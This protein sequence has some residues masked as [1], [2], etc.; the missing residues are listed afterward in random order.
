MSDLLKNLNDKQREAVTAPLGP[1][2][3]LAGAGSGKTRAL[4][5]RIAYIIKEKLF[6][7]EEILALTFTNKAA[8]EMKERINKL[9]QATSYKLQIPITMGTFH[10]VC[11]RI[12]RAD[13][14]KLGL[15]YDRNFTIYDSDDSQR[16]VKQIVLELGLSES[17]RPQVFSYYISAAKNKLLSPGQ[18][19]LEN[20]YLQES[21][22]KV[23]GRYK[24]A[25]RENNAVDFDDLLGLAF[26]LFS[27]PEI[28]K[29]YQ[30]RFHYVLVDEYQ[31]TNH[32]QYMLLR[33]L[34]APSASLRAGK[35]NL[36]VV[37]DDAQS[38][39]GFRGANMQNILDFKKDYSKARVIMLEQNYRS[40]KPILDVAN[41]V[42]RLNPFQY[43]KKLWTSNVAGNKVNLYEA[44]D[45]LEEARFILKRILNIESGI[46]NEITYKSEETPIL[47]RFARRDFRFRHIPYSNFQIPEDLNESVI[48]YR[49]H[50]QSRP[51]EEVLVSSGVPYQ[52][53]GGIRFYERREIKDVLA[54][55]RLMQNPRD[56]VSLERVINLPARGIGRVALKEIT[57]GLAKYDYNFTRMLNN[58]EALKLTDKALAGARD[59][60]GLFS[61]IGSPPREG[62]LEGVAEQKDTT[63]SPSPSSG[64]G[65]KERNILEVMELILKR[66]GYKEALLK[67]GKEGIDRWENVEELF[68]VA[69]KF[70]RLPWTVGLTTMLEEVTLMS[71]LDRVEDDSNKLTLMTL[72]SAKGLEFDNVFFVGLEEGLLPHARSMMNPEELAEE[73]RLAYVGIT[74]ARKNLYLSYARTRSSYGEIKKSVPSRILKAIPKKFINRLS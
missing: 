6:K 53:V 57:T 55:L 45:E 68:N 34:A 10:S 37:G 26:Q 2:L 1:V 67:E 32:V 29:K 59:F 16:L 58:L 3:I 31:D 54:F 33:L 7:P 28:L 73:V 17:F 61:G 48:L 50:A 40:T 9:L 8:G 35:A 38:I 27:V 12:L 72:H 64:G 23:A 18:L 5:A 22:E 65:E 15:G 25:L 11:L 20:E 44:G 69:G 41:E 49:T 21:L 24:Q 42:I 62:E 13:I 56:L 63:T 30:E 74:R 71:D 66:S 43:E 39:Y 47:D 14:E 70:S 46:S 60:F 19:K 36:F 4:T 52:I 51:I